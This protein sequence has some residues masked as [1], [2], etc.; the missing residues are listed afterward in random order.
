MSTRPHP[1]PGVLWAV[2]L[3]AGWLALFMRPVA[4]AAG[5]GV[6]VAVGALGILAPAGQDGPRAGRVWWIG[7]VA[8]GVAAFTA[9]RMLAM[10]APVPGTL[11]AFVATS[12]AAV[13]EEAF[14][15]RVVYGWLARWGDGVAVVGAATAFAAR[16]LRGDGLWGLPGDL[17]AGLLLGWQR[18]GTGRLAS[19]A[20]LDAHVQRLRS[21]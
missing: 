6:I 18:W 11:L 10:H 1:L 4:T 19:A 16:H 17:A 8:V 9:A 13:S 20:A 12:I 7:V 2:V 14:F 5:W 3:A 15:R 21:V